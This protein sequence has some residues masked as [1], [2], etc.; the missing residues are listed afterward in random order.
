MKPE[1][2]LPIWLGAGVIVRLMVPDWPG[3]NVSGLYVL[4]KNVWSAQKSP[5]S[6]K[7]MNPYRRFHSR[8]RGARPCRSGLVI[9]Q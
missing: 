6:A 9:E 2:D 5:L 7:M 3:A 1:I 4:V 8:N